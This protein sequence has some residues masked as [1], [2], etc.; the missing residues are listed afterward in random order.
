M[1]IK[2]TIEVGQPLGL[3][4]ILKSLQNGMAG[5]GGEVYFV[6]ANGGND[7][8]DK[9]AGRSW[10]TC[11]KTLAFAITQSNASIVSSSVGYGLGWAARNTIFI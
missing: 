5:I 6:D 3:Y 10:E 4:N 7:N 1:N 9:D 11:Y 8:E 2:K